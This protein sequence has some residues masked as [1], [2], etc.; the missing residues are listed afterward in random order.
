MSTIRKTNGFKNDMGDIHIEVKAI[1][2][3]KNFPAVNLEWGIE[4]YLNADDPTLSQDRKLH[5]R[6][7]VYMDVFLKGYTDPYIARETILWDFK[8]LFSV[9]YTINGTCY[10]VLVSDML[11][12][13]VAGTSP[14]IGISIELAIIYNT[15]INDPSVLA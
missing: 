6:L 2:Q 14:M 4:K 12:F 1:D 15:A 5:K 13:G 10:E 7:P 3:L 9:N 8:K 11:D